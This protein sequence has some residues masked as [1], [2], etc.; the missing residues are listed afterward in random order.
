MQ[1]G[2]LAATRETETAAYKQKIEYLETQLAEIRDLAN[3]Q[4]EELKSITSN[5][6]RARSDV[7]RAR[8]TR[9]AA[10]TAAELCAKLAEVGHPCD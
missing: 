2:H 3:H 8:R 5:T 10:A 9:A 6:R 1:K 7:E 4:D